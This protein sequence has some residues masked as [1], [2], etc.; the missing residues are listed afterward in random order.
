MGNRRHKR[1]GLVRKRE[2][3]A[4]AI[5]VSS[6]VLLLAATNSFEVL[7]RTLNLKPIGITLPF[8]SKEAGQK[9]R[10]DSGQKVQISSGQKLADYQNWIGTIKKVKSTETSQ[11]KLAY[12]YEIK[13]D[14]GRT[15]KNVGESDLAKTKKSRY[16]Q[17]QIVK[18][19]SS[20]KENLN[21]RS[22]SDYRTSAG[23]V[24]QV[25]YNHS[26]AAGGYKYDV[27][28]DD[29]GKVTDIQE[30]DLE[31]IYQVKLK[32]E[33]S[34]AQNNDVLRQAFAYAKEH[35]GTILSLPSGKF[36]IGSQTPNKDYLT[37]ASD[38]EIRGD[39]TTL[40]VEGAA[41]WFALA[42]GPKA[43]DGVK[44]FTM[45][46]LNI[47]ASDLD[48]GNHFMIM[49]N[50]GDHWRVLNNSFTMVHKKGSHVF[51]LGGLQNSTFKGN[52]FTGYAPELVNA[53]Q[54]DA[55]LSLHDYYSEAIQLDASSDNGVWDGGLIKAIDPNYG[56]H[57]KDRQISRNIVITDNSFVPYYDSKGNIKA[58]SGSVGQ[59]SSDVGPIKI[60]N[61]VFSNTL[62]DRLNVNEKNKLWL[63]KAVH[64]KLER[65]G[66]VYDNDID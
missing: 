64:L 45:R 60:Y 17:G 39:N 20:A 10:Y 59:H 36:K 6:A 22:L 31:T 49:A 18:L 48:K 2:I 19:K 15:I 54:I 21:G 1:K 35:P 41:Y 28:F 4:L 55:N 50:H 47:K 42:T 12:T 38:T 63:F 30:G 29:G 3:I 58:Y 51:D 56:T 8:V 40:V 33:N 11:Q 57:N 43:T 16:Q 13:F 7:A 46:N 23:R 52:Q 9:S 34:A 5:F 66:T 62:V 44:N 37:L 26:S 14:N 25:S 65:K 32:A 24:E 27:T 53:K 61:N